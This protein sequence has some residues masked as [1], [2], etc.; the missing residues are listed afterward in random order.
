MEFYAH[1]RAALFIDGADLDATC[2]GL[3]FHIDFKKVLE[4][5]RRETRLV[6]ATYYAL[7][8]EEQDYS[9]VRPL[10]DWLG[11]NGYLT[12]SKPAKELLDSTG[13]RFATNSIAV[14]LTIDALQLAPCLDHIV[15]F[16]GSADFRSLLA[17]LQKLGLRVSVVSS[18][19]AAERPVADELRR[20]CDQFLDLADM[21]DLI[22][23]D[24]PGQG[25]ERSRPRLVK[26]SLGKSKS[27]TQT[28]RS[29]DDT[30]L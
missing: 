9:P 29:G 1:E 30:T 25:S 26:T 19:R 2:K 14:E 7:Y 28:V 4:L 21:R 22:A 16:S 11:Y 5:F 3:G 24:T 23:L 6:R 12:V 17:A 15:L 10:V 20:Q 27:R 13:Y 8:S 18:R